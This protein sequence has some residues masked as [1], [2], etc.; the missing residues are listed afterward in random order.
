[1][2]KR[3]AI[4]VASGKRAG[5]D[6]E[7]V[8]VAIGGGQR[9]RAVALRAKTKH[10][11]DE[12][13]DQKQKMSRR[14]TE[15]AKS[16]AKRS[17]DTMAATAPHEASSKEQSRRRHDRKPGFRG[18]GKRPSAL[19]AETAP[20]QRSSGGV[21]RDET[22]V[23]AGSGRGARV[24]QRKHE[25]QSSAQRII[26][27]GRK[28]ASEQFISGTPKTRDEQQHRAKRAREQATE[29]TEQ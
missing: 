17:K 20:H 23:D 2:A 4:R 11:Q 13:V 15:D 26:A 19:Q 3:V 7:E 18:E 27:A 6:L 10:E 1:V 8:V 29:R 28:R 22:A 12:A 9:A 25:R 14:H 16:S 24:L 21:H 5:A